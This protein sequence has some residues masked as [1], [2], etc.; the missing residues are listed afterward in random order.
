MKILVEIA[1]VLDRFEELLELVAR[2]DHV[3]IC[4]DGTPIIE[5]NP[6]PKCSEILEEP[7]AMTNAGRANLPGDNTSNL[8]G[9]YDDY[10]G[11]NE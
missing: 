1:E 4:H 8:D 5:M 2:G 10:G 3:L 9:F 7:S 11:Q 6:F